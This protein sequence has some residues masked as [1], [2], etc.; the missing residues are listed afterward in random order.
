MPEPVDIHSLQK[1]S[2]AAETT[3]DRV[4]VECM[5]AL[6]MQLAE[7]N[8]ELM[9]LRLLLERNH[10]YQTAKDQALADLHQPVG[11]SS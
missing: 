4:I 2:D 3:T 8:E 1:A 7:T 10:E 5:T 9:R 6:C 11:A